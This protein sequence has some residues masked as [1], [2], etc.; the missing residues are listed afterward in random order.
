MG[1]YLSIEETSLSDGE[2]YTILT[3]KAAKSKKESIIAIIAST[4]AV[5]IMKVFRRIPEPKRRRVKEVTLD[6]T[7]NMELTIKKSFPWAKR[8]TD[9]FHVQ[10]LAWDTVKEMRIKH[11]WEALDQES[12]AIQMAR[13]KGVSYKPEILSNGDTLK[14]LLA[15]SRYVLSQRPQHWSKSQVQRAALLFEG[16]PD[17]EKAFGLGLILA[18]IYDKT[19]D[20]IYGLDRLAKWHENV[21]QT[22]FKSFNSIA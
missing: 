14:Q 11:R 9:R 16:Y 17:I 6:M 3:N 20:R 1:E 2:L 22:G 12:D 19:T 4:K 15:R 10:K 5:D 21:R 8:V 18:E 7:A 13:A